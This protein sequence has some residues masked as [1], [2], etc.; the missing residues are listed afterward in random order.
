MSNIYSKI[1]QMKRNSEPANM[2]Y[3]QTPQWISG[4]R[5]NKIY[6]IIILESRTHS[7]GEPC[8]FYYISF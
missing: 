7:I 5:R 8:N 1:A 4:M 2:S 3:S 6:I